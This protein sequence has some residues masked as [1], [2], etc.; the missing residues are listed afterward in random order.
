M[1][2]LVTSKHEG[3]G[4]SSGRKEIGFRPL[5]G[6]KLTIEKHSGLLERTEELY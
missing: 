4:E 3:R 6:V 2:I 1:E 5:V